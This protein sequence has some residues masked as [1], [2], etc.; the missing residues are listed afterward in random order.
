MDW[1]ESRS[2]TI[3]H[4]NLGTKQV[5]PVREIC[6]LGAMAMV[7][8]ISAVLMIRTLAALRGVDPQT[9]RIAIPK[10]LIPDA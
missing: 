2:C 5:R 9:L 7:L 1:C 4:I 6:M 8:L 3:G 10:Q